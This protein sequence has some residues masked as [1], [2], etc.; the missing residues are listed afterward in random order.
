MMAD[1]N[2]M[3][4]KLTLEDL[5][6]RLVLRLAVAPRRWFNTLW[7]PKA[8]AHERDAVR[9]E[10][11]EFITQGWEALEIDATTPEPPSG[12]VPYSASETISG[13]NSCDVDA[14]HLTNGNSRDRS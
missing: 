9:H 3:R 11:V 6:T 14:E 7:A 4:T 2:I 1:Q 8:R 10:L 12:H 13:G 5:R